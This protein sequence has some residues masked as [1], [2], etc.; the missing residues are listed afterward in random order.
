MA[1]TARVASRARVQWIYPLALGTAI[2]ILV[3]WFPLGA[4]LHQQAALNAARSE[5]S[6]IQAQQRN[7]A[8]QQSSI[9]STQAAI[10]MARSQYQLVEPGQSL[11]QVLPGTASGDVA[12]ST[13]DP[14][15][16]PLVSP[17]SLTSLGATP[18]VAAAPTRSGGIGGFWHRLVRTLEFWR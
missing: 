15:Y 4:L 1:H 11:I 7:L 3:A 14:G 18:T 8:A 10:S 2:A 12:A 17:S 13:G 9:S 16:A 5:I 6:L